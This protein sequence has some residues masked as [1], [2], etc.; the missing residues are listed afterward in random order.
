MSV[1]LDGLGFPSG[2]MPWRDGVLIAAAPD[3][4]F[5][6]DRDGDGGAEVRGDPLHRVHP[7]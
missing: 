5:A 1:F 3:I 6:A 2:I 7:G 4:L